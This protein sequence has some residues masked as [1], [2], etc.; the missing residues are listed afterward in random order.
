MKNPPYGTKRDYRKIDLFLKQEDRS[1][2][3]VCSTTWSGTCK[4]AAKS[5]AESVRVHHSKVVAKR[6]K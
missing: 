5:F 6:S 4:E 1:L 2:R 3:Y